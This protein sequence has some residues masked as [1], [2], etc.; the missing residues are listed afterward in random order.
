MKSKK[1]KIK[2]VELKNNAVIIADVH[3]KKGDK[4][5]L[6][7]LKKWVEN[8]PP[9]VFL[10]GDIFHLLLPFKFLVEYNKEAINLI[11]HLSQKTEVYYT[12]GN[13][14]FNIQKIFPYVV[15]GEAFLDVNR[16]VFLTHGD[17][18]DDDF[19]YGFYVK[20][21]RNSLIYN[22]LNYLSLNFLNDW[23]FDKILKKRIECEQLKKF[24]KKIKEKIK[25]YDY[26][27]IIEGH[28]HQNKKMNFYD[29]IYINLPAF[30]CTKSYILIQLEK[31]PIIKEINYDG[32]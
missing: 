25:I 1:L 4:E 7:V 17:L 22:I 13:H 26:D 9:Q 28:Y 15:F 32:R 21:I 11:N 2:E 29:K 20:I 3:Y 19:F 27:I 16:N 5:F 31:N 14:D 24:E 10:L 6:E 18:T 30:I 23:L 8:P 12:P